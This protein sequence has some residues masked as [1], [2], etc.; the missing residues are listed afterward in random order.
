MKYN[1]SD[2]LKNEGE[3]THQE[4]LSRMSAQPG[5]S[6]LVWQ[7]GFPDWRAS[8]EVFSAMTSIEPAYIY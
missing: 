1:Y 8:H 2:G 6:H 3:L 5:G 4:I 7:D